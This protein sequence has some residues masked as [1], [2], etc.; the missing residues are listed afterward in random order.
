MLKD[1][2]FFKKD[3]SSNNDNNKITEENLK[4]QDIDINKIKEI[5]GEN[6]DFIVK[7]LDYKHVHLYFIYFE[8]LSDATTVDTSV[9]KP[10]IDMVKSKTNENTNYSNIDILK[11]MEE[12]LIPHRSSK[13]V[14][15][16]ND[17]I[18]SLLTGSLGVVA[19]NIKN[20]AIAFEVKKIE[21][22]KVSEPTNENIIKGSKEAFIED[23]KINIAL[24]RSRIKNPNLKAVKLEVGEISKTDITVMYLND[25]VDKNLLNKVV[26]KIKNMKTNNIVA[27]ADFEEQ[28]I[29]NKYSI[30]PQ[31][32]YT[33]K[34]D[35]VVSNICDGKIAVF[36]DGLPIV[37]ILPAVISMFLQAPEDY[38]ENYAV[39]TMLRVIR[40][41]A[42]ILTLILPGFYISIS[43]FHQEMIPTDLA[44]SIIHSKEGEPFP[45]L[46]EVIFML[47][48][49]EMLIEASSRLP[50]T[51]GQTISIVG[52]LIIGEAAVNAKFVSPAVVVIIAITGIT[53]FL[54]PNQDFANS[55]R[56]C[57]FLLVFLSSIAGLYGLSIGLFMLIYYLCSIE[58]FGVPYLVPFS[59]SDGKNLMKDTIMRAPL[60][61][62]RN[63][64]K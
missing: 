48:A 46:V 58:S 31:L 26:E 12:G 27:G 41:F 43:I 25:I 6:S 2:M 47:L 15:N 21:K 1:W 14:N 9:L 49:F 51:I 59:S 5:L 23:I 44:L 8:T 54:M 39:S 53:G 52:G 64:D 22:R 37:Y 57:R 33:E 30:F 56:L 11:N 7:E 24:V 63:K 35:K 50:K 4:K 20:E 29:D 40:F 61:D 19:S 34:T 17:F 55:L 10:I 13:I 38:S 45:T 62:M 16:L 32:I 42:T 18:N 28:I 60:L 3:K 36:I